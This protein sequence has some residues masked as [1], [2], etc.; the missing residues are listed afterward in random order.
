MDLF[1][2]IFKPLVFVELV[3]G[4]KMAKTL[5]QRLTDVQD[6]ISYVE[7]GRVSEYRTGLSSVVRLPLSVLYKQEKELIEKINIYGGNFVE[8]ANAEQ[9]IRSN[10]IVFGENI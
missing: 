5:S 1:C 4:L 2:P 8:G 6:A 10:Y 9:S 7:G 3:K